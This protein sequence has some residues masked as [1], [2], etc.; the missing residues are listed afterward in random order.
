MVLPT[1]SLS[2]ESIQVALLVSVILWAVHVFPKHLVAL[3]TRRVPWAIHDEL[4]LDLRVGRRPSE[5]SSFKA[6]PNCCAPKQY[7]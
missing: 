4:L 5:Q 3:G 1:P 2:S 7:F 6:T